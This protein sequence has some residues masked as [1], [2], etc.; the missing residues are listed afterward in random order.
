MNSNRR[1]PHSEK[2]PNSSNKLLFVLSAEYE[3]LTEL[4]SVLSS[5]PYWEDFGFEFQPSHS[6][7]FFTDV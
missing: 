4:Q 2:I 1:K 7:S 5:P 6:T 3:H